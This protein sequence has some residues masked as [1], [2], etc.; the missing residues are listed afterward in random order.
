MSI[1]VYPGTFDPITLGHL[2]I[3]ERG[4]NVFDTIVIACI[5]GEL[6][7]KTL[8]SFDERMQMLKSTFGKHKRVEIDS[9]DGLLVHYLKRKK[10]T[11][12][13]RGIRTVEDFEYEYQMTL[14]NRMLEVNVE[15]VFMLTEGNF[16][17]LSSSLIKEIAALGGDV[18]KMVP[19]N[20]QKQLI[21]KLRDQ[22]NA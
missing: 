20:V 6:H 11:T 2:N 14:A 1:A 7:K 9:F 12:I 8:F 4:L 10:V 13:L 16:G 3:V 17:H 22:R 21:Q 5:K 18:S 19:A 15:T